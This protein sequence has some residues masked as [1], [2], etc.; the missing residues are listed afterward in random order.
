[1]ESDIK[2]LVVTDTI[3]LSTEKKVKKI[4]ILSV[5]NL[6]GEAILRIHNA[7]SIST[8]FKEVEE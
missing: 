3:K 1:V 6:L 2:E 4:K 8:L 5:A 7:E